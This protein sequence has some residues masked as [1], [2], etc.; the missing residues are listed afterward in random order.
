MNTATK[1][2]RE[3]MLRFVTGVLDGLPEFMVKQLDALDRSDVT[4][5][6]NTILKTFAMI[7]DGNIWRV[8]REVIEL[9]RAGLLA[10]ENEDALMHAFS[11]IEVV[12]LAGDLAQ[13]VKRVELTSSELLKLGINAEALGH[14]PMTDGTLH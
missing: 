7:N 3:R 9:R 2:D 4:D 11:V 1:A 14:E 6:R 12:R 5:A 13:G 10:V 8:F